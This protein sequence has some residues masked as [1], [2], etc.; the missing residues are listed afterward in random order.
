[1]TLYMPNQLRAD[2]EAVAQDMGITRN[3]LIIRVLQE[4]LPSSSAGL[5][6]TGGSTVGGLEEAPVAIVSGESLATGSP[7][8]P[9]TVLTSP[10]GQVCQ[11]TQ[12]VDVGFY[13][14]CKACGATV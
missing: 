9:S 4:S 5:S 6:A 1:M 11:H 2:Y 7:G 8:E 3:Q 12:V 14:R 13:T 10:N